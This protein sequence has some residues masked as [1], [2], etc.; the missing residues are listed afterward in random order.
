MSNK[1]NANRTTNPVVRTDRHNAARQPASQNNDEKYRDQ[2]TE[3][4][5]D[6]G[7]GV[8]NTIK[9]NAGD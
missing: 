8:F 7:R 2:L 5:I 4:A 1:K 3:L 9:D 6:A